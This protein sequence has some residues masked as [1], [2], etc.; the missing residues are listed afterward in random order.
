MGTRGGRNGGLLSGRHLCLLAGPAA[1]PWRPGKNRLAPSHPRTA[2]V[3]RTVFQTSWRQDGFYRAVY[4]LVSARRGES[5][6]RH[7]ENVLAHFSVLQPHGIGGLFHHL[8]PDRIFFRVEMEAARSLAGP[9]GTLSD[10]RGAGHCGFRRDFQ[11][12]RIRVLGAPFPQKPSAEISL[13]KAVETTKPTKDT[14]LFRLT[15]VSILIH[16]FT[17]ES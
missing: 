3:A 1:G 7:V 2:K 6:G 10:F 11:T 15:N 16:C 14:K 17:D 8:H 9:H 4:L 13:K 12:F 5:A